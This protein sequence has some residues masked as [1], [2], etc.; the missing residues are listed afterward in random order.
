MCEDLTEQIEDIWTMEI[1][2]YLEE[3]FCDQPDKIH[4]FRWEQIKC[5][6]FLWAKQIVLNL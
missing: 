4:E 5:K 2:P 6:V 3:Y 1:E